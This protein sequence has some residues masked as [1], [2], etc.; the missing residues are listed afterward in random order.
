MEQPELAGIVPAPVTVK[1]KRKVYVGAPSTCNIC[2]GPFCGQM[3]D[4]KTTTGPWANM[5]ESCF[6]FF[7]VGLGTGLGQ[8]YVLEADGWI[9][10]A[11]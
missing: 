8:R 11:G 5:C 7:G 10:V 2:N 3:Y 1:S 6:R 4:G 9:K